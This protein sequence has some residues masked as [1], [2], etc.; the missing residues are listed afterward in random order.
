MSVVR[1]EFTQ[2]KKAIVEFTMN[3]WNYGQVTL[4]E[5]IKLLEIK[6]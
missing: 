6:S 5:A 2:K 1:D 3:R 4:P